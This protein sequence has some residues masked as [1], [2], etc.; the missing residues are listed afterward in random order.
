M[1]TCFQTITI[2]MPSTPYI[3]YGMECVP[4]CPYSFIERQNK[5]F[6]ALKAKDNSVITWWKGGLVV[7]ILPDGTT[8]TWTPKPTLRD[9]IIHSSKPYNNKGWYVEF[10]SDKSI[11]AKI[12]NGIYYWSAPIKGAIQE[13][14]ELT[15]YD[16][17][18]N[19]YDEEEIES[20]FPECY[21][22]KED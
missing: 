1:T 11:V 19:E 10:K 3:F 5:E 14:E 15:N 9:I 17:D 21:N 6:I 12:Y 2:E 18:I 13:G 7:K 4:I 20:K 8:K 16:Y 22:C